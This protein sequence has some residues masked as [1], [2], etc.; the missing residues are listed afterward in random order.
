MG[1][2]KKILTSAILTHTRIYRITIPS[3]C[4]TATTF[5]YPSTDEFLQYITQRLLINSNLVN[6]DRVVG[7]NASLNL[8]V[9]A[10]LLII[11]SHIKRDIPWPLFVSQVDTLL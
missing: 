11:A 4:T 2:F 8:G 1:R 7:A 5:S 9:R 10:E 3:S 6:I